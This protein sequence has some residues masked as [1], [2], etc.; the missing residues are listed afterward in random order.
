MYDAWISFEH[1][2]GTLATLEKALQ[3]VETELKYLYRR[4]AKVST[5][6]LYL[7]YGHGV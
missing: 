6:N 5:S 1:S 7:R 2:D 3:T 4:R